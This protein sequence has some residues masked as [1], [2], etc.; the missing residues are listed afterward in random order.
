M[1]ALVAGFAFSAL[2]ASA[3]A[4]P[5]P[6]EGDD[7]PAK[8]R[9][10]PVDKTRKLI[11]E[12]TV[13]TVEG[14]VRVP[15][16][17]EVT[18]LRNSRVVAKGSQPAV[19]EVEGGFDAIGVFT[20]EVIFENVTVEPQAKYERIHMDMVIFRGGGGIKTPKDVPVEGYV[21]L[22]NLDFVNGAAMDVTYQT[23]SVELSTVCS[24][25]P[26]RIRAVDKEGSSKNQVRV[27]I[28]GCPQNRFYP[29]TPHG[30]R[31][32]LTGGLEVDGGDDVTVQLSRV[33]GALCA[34]RN[35]GQKLIF[36][37]M[38][39][40][41]AKVEFSHRAAGMFQ[42]V[43]CAKCDVYSSEWS[44]RAPV[45]KGVKD[46]F[47]VDRCWFRGRTDLKEIFD[48]V[49]KDG[50]DD[51]EKNGVRVQIPKVNARPLELAGP[52]ER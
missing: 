39:V 2:L 15:K 38:K 3:P 9:P 35:W 4:A 36:D 48:Q 52:V 51:P 31:V 33:G 17:V 24:D 14:R 46:T 27:F 21:L 23:G 34:V 12:G 6:A 20:R 42:R 1:R 26:V 13:Y 19:I 18:I 43:Q 41:A 50:A 44:A 8:E 40:N 37:G 25:T 32:G 28:R 47:T 45:E 22:E 10:L 30:G 7:P 5:V 29:C 49:V 11:E 16:G